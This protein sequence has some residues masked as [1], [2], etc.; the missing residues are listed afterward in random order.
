MDHDERYGFVVSTAPNTHPT[1]LSSRHFNHALGLSDRKMPEQ[2]APYFE[3]MVRATYRRAVHT[4]AV[5]ESMV[6]GTLVSEPSDL[7]G[8]ARLSRNNQQFCGT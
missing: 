6:L 2:L 1:I 8:L 3:S 5:E 7:A 4:P